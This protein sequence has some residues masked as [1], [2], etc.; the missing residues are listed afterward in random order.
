[1]KYVGG[2]RKSGGGRKQMVL[3]KVVPRKTGIVS[4]VLTL[5]DRPWTTGIFFLGFKQKKI[6]CLAF[7]NLFTW[8]HHV[9]LQLQT[10]GSMSTS[11]PTGFGINAHWNRNSHFRFKNTSIGTGSKH[12]GQNPKNSVLMNLHISIFSSLR[13]T[14]D[15]VPNLED[16][17]RSLRVSDA[18]IEIT[19]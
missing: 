10:E 16:S 4:G 6:H 15:L 9:I 19:T 13:W 2:V 18:W 5:L 1:M 14:S 8:L 11:S 12:R 17:Q 3:W 7:Y